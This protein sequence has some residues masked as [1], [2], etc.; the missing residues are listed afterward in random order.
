VKRRSFSAMKREYPFWAL[1]IFLVLV[2]FTGGGSRADI[3]SLIILR[4]AAVVF[5]GIGLWG[6]KWDHVNAYRFLFA[7]T[8]AIFALLLLHLIP[9]PPSIWKAIPGRALA[10]EIDR[11]AE[12]GDVWRPISLVPSATWNA[13][14]ALFVPLAVLILAVQVTREQRF[15]LLP[16]IIGLGLFSG[17]WG[18]LQAIGPSDGPLYLYRITNK[19]AAVGL[20][21][22]R[23]HQAVFLAC[24]FPMLAVYASVGIRTVEQAKIRAGLAIGAG[25]VL[26]PLLLVTGSRAGLIV[27]ALGLLSVPLLYRRPEVTQPKKRKIQRFDPRYLIGVGGVFGLGVLTILMARA[28]AF[29]RLMAQ[30]Q[31][32]D[33]RFKMW[34]P[35][36][37][38]AEK[39]FPFG[40]GIGSFVEVYQIDEPLQL[41]SPNYVNHAHNDWLEVYLT[42]GLPG[43]LLL[44]LIIFVWARASYRA[45]Q[46]TQ[47]VGRDAV[48]AQSAAIIVALL[49]LASVADYPLRVPILACVFVIVAV[50][51]SGVQAYVPKKS[52]SF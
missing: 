8:A 31:T 16:V 26:V 23:N 33:L 24:L 39:Y 18:M 12:F 15:Q 4:P 5:V 34:G 38:M 19:G 35:I 47:S 20:L 43:L 40:S 25:V 3:Q 48:Y 6:L 21:S 14:Y 44:A 37:S 22:N 27:G 28:Q 41:L 52:G 1:I 45:F 49:A 42:V 10:A 51:L 32:E 29:E 36:A 2:F 13:F 17:F 11:V 50:W 30:D 46:T 9:L 7:V